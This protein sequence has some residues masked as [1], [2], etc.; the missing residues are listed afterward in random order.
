MNGVNT[1]YTGCAE[2]ASFCENFGGKIAGGLLLGKSN[3]ASLKVTSGS[4]IQTIPRAGSQVTASIFR[5]CVIL[6]NLI[7]LIRSFLIYTIHYT[8]VRFLSQMSVHS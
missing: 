6:E 2:Y 4:R 3:M 5:I 8:R 7:H 1:V